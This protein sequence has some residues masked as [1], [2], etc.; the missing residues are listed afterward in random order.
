VHRLVVAILLFAVMSLAVCGLAE[1]AFATTAV[2][3]SSGPALPDGRVAELVTTAV[4]FGEPYQPTSPLRFEEVGGEPTE[5]P[6]EAAQNGDAVTYVGEPP[7][8]GGTGETGPG[9]GD[10]WLATRSSSG[11]DATA[12]TPALR[13]AEDPAYQ[14]FSPDL[15]SQIFEGGDEP[16]SSGVFQGCRDLYARVLDGSYTALFPTDEVHEAEFEPCGHPLFAGESED[17]SQLIFQSE[18][19]LTEDAEEATEVPGGHESHHATGLESGEPCMFGCNLY[20]SVGGILLLVS[21]L[22]GKPVPNAT[23]GGYTPGKHNLT[24]FSHAISTDGSRIFWTDTQEGGPHFEHVYVLEDG[25]TTVEVSGPGNAEYLTATPDGHYAFYSEEGALWRFDTH[26]N[27]RERITAEGA[28]VLGV[29]G[30]NE[31]GA[32]GSYLYFVAEGVLAANENEAEEK[33]SSGQP[34]LYLLH[35]GTTNEGTTTFIA[36]LSSQDN[37]ISTTGVVSRPGGDWNDNLGN[38]TATVTPDGRHLLFESVR[39]L[40]GYANGPIVNGLIAEAFIY[41]ADEG[42]LSCVSCNPTGAPPSVP[43]EVGTSGEGPETRL[44]VSTNSYTYIRR[45]MSDSGDRVFFDSEQPLVA[46]DTNGVQDVYEWEREGSGSCAVQEPVRP[47]HGCIYL[48]SGGNNAGFSFLV[49]ADTTGDNVFLEHQG[50]L[51]Q[52]QA[53]I[54]RNELYDLRVDG[55]FPEALAACAGSACQNNPPAPPTFA[56]PASLTSS[57]TGNFSPPSAPKPLTRAQKLAKALKACKAV[58]KHRRARCEREARKRYG[59]KFGKSAK[60]AQRHGGNR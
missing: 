44:P 15:S 42:Q 17:G 29:I 50:P 20:E 33:A 23:F 58:P 21:T 12:I 41:N 56:T 51:G 28:G 1:Q 24:N 35:E 16:L 22:E 45:W 55:G 32:P 8:F 37:S 36:T 10:Q 6:F 18:A 11:W 26:A 34:N 9:E 19:A 5:H 59:P 60:R 43:E 25:A 13:N 40:T 27:T 30:L 46:Q 54:D 2:P 49:D 14:A 53:Q 52:V 48:L 4:G 7:A 3:G 57:G 47:E 39:S 31:T 38:R